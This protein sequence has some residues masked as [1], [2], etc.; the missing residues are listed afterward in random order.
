IV[1]F[2][3]VFFV[4]GIFWYQEYLK[5]INTPIS[6]WLEDQKADCAVT[7]TGGPHRVREGLDLLSQKLVK[8]L[9]IAGTNPNASLR[10][11]F[12]EWPYY[13]ELNE[14]DVILEK[15]SQTTYG[16]ARQTLALVEALKC[17]DIV[18]VTDRLH[19]NRAYSTFK[20]IYPDHFPILTRSVVADGFH[21][22]FYKVAVEATKSLFYRAL[23]Y[24]F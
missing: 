20:S 24:L 7:L 15:H 9:I 12:P 4:L 23:V 17:R 21:P 18:L 14:A 5:I 13:G 8:K 22:P 6:A 3:I 11:I 19:M 10:E 1:T 2:S 16:N